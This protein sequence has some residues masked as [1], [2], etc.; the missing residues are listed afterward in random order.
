M[1]KMCKLRALT[2]LMFIFSFCSVLADDADDNIYLRMIDD[3]ESAIKKQNFEKAEQLLT[4][5]ISFQPDNPNNALLM[6]NLGMVRFYM[7][8]D[9]S[10]IITLNQAHKMAPSSVTI[11]LNRARVLSATGDIKRAVEDYNRV[12]ELDSTV[13]MP[14]LF[15]GLLYLSNG[16]LQGAY[17]QFV[18]ITKYSPSSYDEALAFANY[19]MCQQKYAEAKP[20]YNTLL[21]TEKT[22]ENYAAHALC[23]IFTDDLDFAS[24][25]ISAGLEQ[26]PMYGELYLCRALLYKRRYLNDDAKKDASKAKELGVDAS[27]VDSMLGE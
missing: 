11:L 16:D 12:T 7:N 27:V 18:N 23:C 9:S 26:N 13:V 21:K 25:D 19:Y 6:S 22:A 4:D 24:D 1:T 14:Y 5:A 10:A 20:Y 2:M 3:A 17:A 8:N 15:R